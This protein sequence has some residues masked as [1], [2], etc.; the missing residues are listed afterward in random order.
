MNT[1]H[2][3]CTHYIH[4]VHTAYTLCTHCI[5]TVHTAYTLHRYC[6]HTV[7]TTYTLYTLRIHTVHTSVH[8]AYTLLT[9]CTQSVHTAYTLLRCRYLEVLTA[10]KHDQE[11]L[12]R[13][14]SDRSLSDQSTTLPT[15]TDPTPNGRT[16]LPVTPTGSGLR[17]GRFLSSCLRN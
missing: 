13:C 5:H 16:T 1:L 17:H 12:N 2:T 14:P 9:H 7:H 11:R 8:T 6:I 4:T 15:L 10:K 3:H